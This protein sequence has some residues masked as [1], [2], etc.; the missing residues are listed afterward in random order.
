MKL[1]YGDIK[2]NMAKVL[3][4]PTAD[5]RVV[6]YVNEAQERLVYKGK[7]P[8]TLA[9]YS[10]TNSDGTITWPRQL[11]TIES[12]AV[13]DTP[14]IIRNEWYEFLE[15]G[16]GLRDSTDGDS[17]T[18]I[19][20]GSA[21]SFSDIITTDSV[22][23][24]LKAYS[25]DDVDA[26]QTMIF[27]GYDEDGDWIRTLDGSNH[28]DGEKV[29]LGIAASPVTTT[30]KF[31]IL[32]GVLR[33]E[34]N[35]NVKVYEYNT[36]DTTERLIAEYEPTETRPTYRRSLIPGLPDSSTKTVTIIG[37]LRFVP[38]KNDNDWLYINFEAAL[39]LMV[40]AIRKEETNNIQEAAAFERQAIGLLQDQLMHHTGDGVVAVPR[41]ININTFGGGSVTNLT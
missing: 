11:E 35:Y 9:M 12:V 6:D 23:K 25:G 16:P 28:I 7:W 2:N 24:T 15:A 4:L 41:F 38:V 13:D 21:V 31:S 1:T 34:T 29:T 39:K 22:D 36:F 37:K 30:K 3:S 8:G 10:V 14:G 33:D 20:R 26:G 32:S 5:S 40:M 19:D 18:L 27:Q 17:L